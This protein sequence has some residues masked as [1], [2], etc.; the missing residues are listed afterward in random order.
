[1]RRRTLLG[2]LGA[3][4]AATS[5]P[6]ARRPF[7]VALGS[8]SMHGLAHI[9]VV[10]A[11]E[12]LGLVPDVI[13]GCSAGAIVG[14]L[15]AAGLDATAIERHGRMLDWGGSTSWTLPWRGLKRSGGLRRTV[16]DAVGH[17]R[18]EQLPRRFVAVACDLADGSLVVI[19]QGPVD[20]AVAA[21][22][23]MPV[24]FVPVHLGTREVV[25]G[26]LA[27][28]VPVDVARDRAGARAV[29][30]AVDVAYRPSEEPPRWLGDIAF[31]TLH[32]LVNALAA[33]QVKRADVAMRLSLHHLMQSAETM[34]SAL[35]EA[36][37][38]AMLDAWPRLRT[39]LG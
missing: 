33:E 35:I 14:S 15:W 20:L 1:M 36:G 26:S 18:I 25:D 22:S 23:A 28:P 37:E 5:A 3:T 12:R 8:G 31:Q 21:S 13:V 32:I 7:A 10:R 38:K 34:P 2:G 6:A 29:V 9:G 19:D 11:C 16:A 30:L 17:R 39:L 27:A 4:M 24:L